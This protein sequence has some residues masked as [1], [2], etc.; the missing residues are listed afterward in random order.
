MDCMAMNASLHRKHKGAYLF[1]G[2]TQFLGNWSLVLSMAGHVMFLWAMLFVEPFPD[3]YRYVHV[4]RQRRESVYRWCARFYAIYIPFSAV[5]TASH[6]VLFS[7]GESSWP[8][9]E[10]I[11]EL[12]FH[13]GAGAFAWFHFLVY[14]PKQWMYSPSRFIMRRG[15]HV[16]GIE[17]GQSGVHAALWGYIVWVSICRLF[18]G[19]WAYSV[20]NS[21]QKDSTSAMALL[22]YVGAVAALQ[23]V[24]WGAWRFAAAVG[25]AIKT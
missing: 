19:R 11:D 13:F 22:Q 20:L 14:S 24:G 4:E 8:D 10:D 5:A 6:C 15:I 1:G 18:S 9:T 25:P 7:A 16:L 3:P 21:F 23:A 17:V 2:H 12:W